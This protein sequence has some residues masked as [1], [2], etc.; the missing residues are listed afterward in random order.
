MSNQPTFCYGYAN[1]PTGRCQHGNAGV[2]T[3]DGR[4]DL[5]HAANLRQLEQR[6]RV[7]VE[8]AMAKADEATSDRAPAGS[9]LADYQRD[10]ARHW[11][12]MAATAL[13][14]ADQAAERAADLESH[15]AAADAA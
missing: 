5:V 3:L 12:A 2:H 13:F 4:E 8:H 10:I 11:S 6:L 7:D 15:A 1:S 14:H 9:V